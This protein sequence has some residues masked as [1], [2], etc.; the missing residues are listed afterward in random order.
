MNII[1]DVLS[2]DVKC[3]K[4]NVTLNLIGLDV[5]LKPIKLRVTSAFDVT[6]RKVDYGSLS[7][8]ILSSYH[9][10]MINSHISTPS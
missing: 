4:I 8:T 10:V 3:R 2:N 6:M 7:N 9:M 1:I 5:F